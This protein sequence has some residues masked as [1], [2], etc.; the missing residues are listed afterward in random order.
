MLQVAIKIGVARTL[1]VFWLGA[2]GAGGVYCIVCSTLYHGNACVPRGQVTRVMGDG[3][4]AAV[5]C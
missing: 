4:D 2:N 5:C 3:W 1:P